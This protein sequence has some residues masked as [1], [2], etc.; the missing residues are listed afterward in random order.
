MPLVLVGMLMTGCTTDGDS[1][2]TSDGSATRPLRPSATAPA[3][4]GAPLD[5]RISTPVSAVPEGYEQLA[6]DVALPTSAASRYALQT[7]SSQGGLRLFAKTGLWLRAGVEL[8]IVPAGGW[9]HRA[10]AWWGNNV[11]GEA[12]APL[13]FRGG[14]CRG[15]GWLVFPGGFFVSSVGCVPFDVDVAGR[16][17]R[18]DVGI[19]APCAG[20]RPPPQPSTT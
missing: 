17:F 19:G 9:R 8:T 7:A 3:L 5:C 12:I 18:V 14:P 16:T 13:P 4:N 10:A 6:G 11:D 20:Q 2:G 1:S 15:S